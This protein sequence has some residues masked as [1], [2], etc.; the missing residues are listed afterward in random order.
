M[1]S[2]SPYFQASFFFFF[3]FMLGYLASG[4]LAGD[5]YVF[6]DWTV[7]YLTTSPLRDKQQVIG[8]NGQFPG[9]ILNITTNWNVF[10]NV[11]NVLDEPLLLTWNGLQHRENAWQD[12]VSGT[13]CSIPAGWNWKYEFQGLRKDLEKG[14]DLGVHDG[15]LINVLGPYRYD[16]ALV[17][18]GIVYQIINVE[19]GKTY[20]FRVHNVGIFTSLNFR[21]QGHNLLLAETE[22]SYTVQQNYSNMDIHVR[23]SFSFLGEVLT[24]DIFLYP[25]MSGYMDLTIFLLF[26]SMDFGLWTEDSRGT[27]NK[28]DGVARSTTRL[29]WSLDSNFSFSRQCRHLEST[30]TESRFMVSRPRRL[31]KRCESRGRPFGGSVT[32]KFY[33]LW[34]PVVIIEAQRVNFSGTTSISDSSKTVLNVNHSLHWTLIQSHLNL[35]LSTA[36]SFSISG[37]PPLSPSLRV[38]LTTI[39]GYKMENQPPRTMTNDLPE[40]IQR[41]DKE[42]WFHFPPA[43]NCFGQE[44]FCLITGLRFGRHDEVGKEDR[45]PISEDLILLVDDLDAWNVFPWGSYLWKATWKKLSTAFEDRH[46]LRDH[47]S[48]YTLVGFIW[49]FKIW[50]FEAFPS[51]QTYAIKKLND[52]PRAITW[53]RI[54]LLDWEDL[55]PY[56][57]MNDDELGELRD[58]VSALRD[59]VG[60][61]CDDNGAWRDEVRSLRGEVD[62]LR[63]ENGA[64]RGEV[65]TLRDEVAALREIVS[66]LQN[67]V[68]T[69]RNERSDKVDVLRRVFL[70]RRGSRIRRRARAITSPFTPIVPRL[71]KKKLDS[72]VIVQEAPHII[73]EAPLVV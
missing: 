73:Q 7:S 5:P 22:G 20:C 21:I 56:T 34:H 31:F 53:R 69:L 36:A 35:S 72:L 9:P 33:I 62:I 44:E 49:A 58:E 29:P 38:T 52:I 66:S 10:V 57:T 4:S 47:G 55:I 15:I 24:S 23:Q 26:R 45:Q 63:D 11:K 6:Y 46:S 2:G 43:Y 25:W 42:I 13:N 67:E 64:L 16:Q 60:T 50:I 51:M 30:C 12:G 8:I 37:D 59:E 27:S 32:R 54:W 70:A 1:V 68:H 71:R 48:K 28:W 65:Y 39:H 19:P 3:F 14:V 41:G 17:K 61:L 40:R 18:D